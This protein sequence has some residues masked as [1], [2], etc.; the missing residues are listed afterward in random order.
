MTKEEKRLYQAAVASLETEDGKVLMKELESF[1]KESK[2]I[3][4]E[5]FDDRACSYLLGRQSVLLHIKEILKG[6]EE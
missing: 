1:C 2:D 5:S 6:D 4:V 3:F